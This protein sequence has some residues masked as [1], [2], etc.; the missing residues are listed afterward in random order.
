MSDISD[1]LAER[2]AALASVGRTPSDGV[3]RLV[4]GPE[5]RR[6]ADLAGTWMLQA[7]LEVRTDQVGNTFGRWHS[8]S[9]APVWTGSHLDSVTE[10][11]RF[12]GTAGV[13][14]ALAAIESLKGSGFEPMRP[15]DV[16]IFVGEEGSRFPGLLGSRAVVDGIEGDLDSKDQDGV[17][18]KE[19]MLAAGLDPALARDAR[20]ASGQVAAYLELHIEQGPVL[21]RA[22]VPV[23]V[24]TAIAGPLFLE[25]TVEGRADHAGTTPMDTRADSFAATA[26]FALELEKAALNSPGVVATI[27]RII[28]RPGSGNVV[29]GV[30]E[31]TVDIRAADRVLREKFE[32]Q[33]RQRFDQLLTRR[34]LK[35]ELR[36]TLR[37]DPVSVPNEIVTVI[38]QAAQ[39][40]G[41]EVL[42]LASG[43]AHDAM[44]ISRI[45][46]AGMIFVRSVGGRSHSPD[47]LSHMDDLV[48]GTQVLAAAIARLCS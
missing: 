41:V 26:E 19:A 24:V 45:A 15:I 32:T 3:T 28:A 31:F 6:A 9:G 2:L 14:A 10:G 29:P 37:V 27:G 18:L 33:M 5:E 34:G 22:E 46:P 42:R 16:C 38:E 1:V 23:G 12:D 7:G 36:E 20:L 13:L 17:C 4:Y 30:T 35:G 11:G 39:D 47:E 21:E 48:A 43:A 25:C 44:V 8:G 40:A